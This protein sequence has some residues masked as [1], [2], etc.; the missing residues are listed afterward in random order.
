PVVSKA[1]GP[2][3]TLMLPSAGGGTNW[4]GGSFDP[5]T[6]VLY[7]HS[8]TT[9]GSLGLVPPPPDMKN[10]LA[11]IQGSAI[12][13]ARRTIGAGSVAG[14]GQASVGSAREPAPEAAAA[15]GGRPPV[16]DRETTRL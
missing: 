2:I 11:Y 5:E 1:E 14:G 8:Q 7:V 9:I 13:G 3:G 16:Q 6:R 12:T 15:G 4:P 10:D